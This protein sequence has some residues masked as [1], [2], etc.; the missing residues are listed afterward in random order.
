MVFWTSCP[1]LLH[2]KV[3]YKR[4]CFA[5]AARQAISI[6]L[7]CRSFPILWLISNS[8]AILEKELKITC[9]ESIIVCSPVSAQLHK[10]PD[11]QE[12]PQI[13]GDFGS[14]PY[15]QSSAFPVDLSSS[16]NCISILPLP[17]I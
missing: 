13:E 8:L 14:H 7:E 6:N 2:E 5:A 9:D 11:P 17:Y 12:K 16:S 3:K 1:S 4:M 15:P 10:D